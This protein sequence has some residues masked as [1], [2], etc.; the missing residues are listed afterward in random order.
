MKKTTHFIFIASF[1]SLFFITGCGK[2]AALY[3]P[4]ENKTDI[5][6]D[7][8]FV[9]PPLNENKTKTNSK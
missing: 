4:T 7:Q 8:S 6:S 5:Q 9:F 3:P 2:K 1:I